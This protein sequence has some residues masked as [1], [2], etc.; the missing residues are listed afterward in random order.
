MNFYLSAVDAQMR[1]P[2][3][4]PSIGLLL[5]KAKSGLVVEYALRDVR[6]PIGVAQ[7]ETR[8]VDSLPKE[9]KGNLPTIQELEAELAPKPKRRKRP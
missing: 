8:I 3:D 5:C 9:L 6:K 4:G 2:E 1:H 7:W